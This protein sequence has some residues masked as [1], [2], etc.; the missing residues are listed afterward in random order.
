MQNK[1]G[2]VLPFFN[3]EKRFDSEFIHSVLVLTDV[4]FIFVDD[5]STDK[6]YELLKSFTEK[7][8]NLTVLRLQNNLGK[9]EAIR[10]GWLQMMKASDYEYLGLMDSDGAITA[11]DLIDIIGELRPNGLTVDAIWKSR[12]AIA[13][14]KG[15]RSIYRHYISR[16]IAT[17]FGL[18]DR[19]LPYDT[20]CGL[21]LFRRTS[22]FIESVECK[23]STRW[24]IDLEM[25]VRLKRGLGKSLLIWEVPCFSWSEIGQSKISLRKSLNLM[26]EMVQVFLQLFGS[27]KFVK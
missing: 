23:F 3:E 4:D 10:H 22:V 7:Y 26:L 9:A 5:G 17:F 11:L 19:G 6:T 25:Y 15:S 16:V 27:R 2:F 8:S 12:I 18:V 24:F 20:Q 13:G 1:F 14:R 21:K